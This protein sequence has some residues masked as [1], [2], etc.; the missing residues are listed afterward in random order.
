[1]RVG[2]AHGVD[3]IGERLPQ[4]IA[5]RIA[6]QHMIIERPEALVLAVVTFFLIS[7]SRVF[8]VG[9]LLVIYPYCLHSAYTG[10]ISL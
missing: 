1:V 9:R 4:L 10:F 2:E 8:C 7:C 3:V 6:M 5:G